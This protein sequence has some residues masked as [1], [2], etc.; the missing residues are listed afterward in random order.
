LVT[1]WSLASSTILL[2]LRGQIL[3]MQLTNLP[4]THPTLEN[5]MEK[6]FSI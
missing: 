5:L 2:K 4:S 1:V 3:S 6:Q